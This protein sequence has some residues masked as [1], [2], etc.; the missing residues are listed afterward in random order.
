[1]SPEV[2]YFLIGIFPVIYINIPGKRLRVKKY[3]PNTGCFIDGRDRIPDIML[4]VDDVEEVERDEFIRQIEQL[5]S[6][7]VKAEGEL[8]AL[9][10]EIREIVNIRR[11]NWRRKSTPEER[12]HFA[13][14]TQRSYHLF[15]STI[16]RTICGHS[17]EYD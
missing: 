2:R 17:E 11:M 1:M 15:E 14:L 12:Q 6:H 8:A 7:D 3:D 16:G 5:R 13:D 10:D 4:R 9:Y